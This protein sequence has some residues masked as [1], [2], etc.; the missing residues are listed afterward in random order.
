VIDQYPQSIHGSSM[1]AAHNDAPAF[2]AAILVI[3]ISSSP[4]APQSAKSDAQD[5]R[6]DALLGFL[7][8]PATRPADD[9]ATI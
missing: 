5:A 2:A 9:N 3:F 6:T 1:P 4:V 7:R 8:R